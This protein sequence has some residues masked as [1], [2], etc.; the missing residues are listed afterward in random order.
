TRGT[1]GRR[2]GERRRRRTPR[3]TRRTHEPRAGGRS[4]FFANSLGA[5]RGGHRTKFVLARCF[6]GKNFSSRTSHCVLGKTTVIKAQIVL[7]QTRLDANGRR[8][9]S[10]P[11]APKTRRRA[12]QRAA[13]CC[14]KAG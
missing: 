12:H 1:L 8:R 7:T 14:D 11:K 2:G 10:T 3:T 9:R 4:N 5:E 13:R 6:C